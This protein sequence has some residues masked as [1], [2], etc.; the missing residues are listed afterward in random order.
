MR[1]GVVVQVK[2]DMDNKIRDL[3]SLIPQRVTRPRIEHEQ[4]TEFFLIEFV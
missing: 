3:F 4:N 2:Q 1:F